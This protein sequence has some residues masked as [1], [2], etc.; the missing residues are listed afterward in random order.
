MNQSELEGNTVI[1]P[2]PSGGKRAQTSHDW[3]WFYLRL[4]EKVEQVL[5]TN[6]KGKYFRHSTKNYSPVYV[7]GISCNLSRKT[8]LQIAKRFL[9]V[10]PPRATEF[11]FF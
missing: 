4:I 9:R 7:K 5:K 11:L 1:K 2:A 10:T 8:L 6:Y 3:F